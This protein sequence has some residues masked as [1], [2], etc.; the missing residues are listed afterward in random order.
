MVEEVLSSYMPQCL[1]IAFLRLF[2]NFLDV[3]SCNSI[4]RQNIR[5]NL[6]NHEVYIIEEIL[7]LPRDIHWSWEINDVNMM[8]FPQE[9]SLIWDA[10]L[11]LIRT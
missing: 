5:H 8:D 3:I 7:F 6:I 10:C 4:W 1:P 2:A 11:R 9:V